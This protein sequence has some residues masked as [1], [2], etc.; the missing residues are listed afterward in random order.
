[1][2][3][4]SSGGLSPLRALRPRRAICHEFRPDV[5][6]TRDAISGESWPVRLQAWQRGVRLL[7]MPKGMSRRENNSTVFNKACVAPAR[8]PDCAGPCLA[9]CCEGVA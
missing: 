6:G 8:S 2:S 1:V 3:S 9:A 5:A 7:L 4:L